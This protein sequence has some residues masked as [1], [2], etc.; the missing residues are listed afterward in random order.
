MSIFIDKMNKKELIERIHLLEEKERS[1]RLKTNKLGMFLYN[2]GLWEIA[3]NVINE[4]RETG[5]FRID[6]AEINKAIYTCP[7]CENCKCENCEN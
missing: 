7:E 3:T 5:I 1:S 4:E 2:I 6:I